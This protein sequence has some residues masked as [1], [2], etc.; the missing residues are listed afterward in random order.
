MILNPQRRLQKNSFS[1]EDALFYR[2]MTFPAEKLHI[3]AEKCGFRGARCRKP[4]EI[5]RGFQGSRVKNGSQ[6]SQETFWPRKKPVVDT[7]SL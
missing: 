7:K 3:P 4:Q 2:K 1:A 5:A 6:L